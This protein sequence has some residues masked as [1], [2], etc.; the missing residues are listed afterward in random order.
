MFP[1]RYI[2]ERKFLDKWSH[3]GLSDVLFLASRDGAQFFWPG[4]QAFLRPGPDLNNWHERS[5]FIAPHLLPAGGSEMAFYSVQ[6]YRTKSIHLRRFTLRVDGFVSARADAARGTLLTSPL[7]F[8]GAQ[9]QLNYATSAAGSL[10]VE[11]LDADEQP[12][13]GF[14]TAACSE[15]FGDELERIVEWNKHPDLEVLAG[16]PVRLRFALQ[17]ADLYSF[18]FT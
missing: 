16:H 2:P 9:L 13:P 7:V 8:A 18:K 14:S 3:D 5:I 4:R 15:I 6:N 1:N 10:R 12:L 11:I 17:E